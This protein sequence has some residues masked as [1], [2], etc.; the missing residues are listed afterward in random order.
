MTRAATSQVHRASLSHHPTMDNLEEDL[1][2]SVCYSLFADP[3][4]LPCSHTFCKSCLDNVLQVSAVYSIWRPLRLPLKCPNCRSVVELPPTGVDALPINVSLRA[5]I[6]KFQKDSQPQP[7]SCPE[8]HRQPLNI[9]CV[10]DR[11]LI[12]GFCLT[13][14]QH[15]GHPIDDLQAAFIRERQAPAHLLGRLSDH[16]WAEVCE[17]GEQLEQEK[18]SCEGLVRQDRQAVEQYFQGLELV[19]SRKKEAFMGALDTASM[20]VSLAYNPLIQ[21]LKEL[22]EEQ[23]DL[24]SLGSA[25]E[26]EDSPLVF[27]EKVYLFRERVEALV[28]A[29]LPEVTSLTITPR[30][31]EYLEQHWVGVTIGV[32]EEGPVPRVCCCAKSTILEMVLRT[33][34]RSQPGGWVHDLWQQL[35]PTPPVVL[36]GMGML[37]LLAAVWVNPV[38]GASLGFSLLS[39]L[40]QMVHGLSS[41]LTTSLWETTGFLYAQTGEVVW[42]YSSALST[43][44]ENTYQ[45]LASLYKTLSS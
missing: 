29:T 28:N 18:A 3:R 30:A 27:L 7:P 31:A 44:G 19:L 26:D 34:T 1:T 38:G 25:V 5:I 9:Y 21:R 8:H 23:L 17:L 12:C 35:H 45:Q 13:V 42:R 41:E 33:E 40:S 37:L 39:Q 15:Q 6:E 20:E 11:Q 43:L 36:L 22:Q 16:R 32:L 24:L 10:Q 2:C 14:G 4:V